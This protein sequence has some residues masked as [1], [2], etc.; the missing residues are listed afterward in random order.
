M[1]LRFGSFVFDSRL[2]AIMRDD[3]PL[4]LSPKAFLLLEA[5][6]EGRP[7]P[8][9]KEVLYQRLWPATFVEPGNLHN[10]IAEIR[11]ALDD[12]DHRIVRTVHGIGYS[13]EGRDVD[14]SLSVSRFLLWIGEEVIPLRT[15]ETIVGRDPTATVVIDSPDVSRQHV[16]LF[17]SDDHVVVEDLRSKNGTYIDSVRL[18]APRILDSPHDITV[19]KTPVLLRMRGNV[20]STITAQ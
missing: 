20:R 5:L 4:A 19:G 16:R 6:I 10:L 1:R 9:S 17:V 18:D 12:R 15:G 11:R 14:L 3:E 13:F 2:R 7:A 8:I